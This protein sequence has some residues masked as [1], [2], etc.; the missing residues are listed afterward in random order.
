MHLGIARLVGILGRGR[1]ID[2]L[3]LRDDRIE[4]LRG[5]FGSEV[6]Q[7]GSGDE[8]ALNIEIILDSGMDA[9]KALGG[10]C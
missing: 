7:R 10:L 2:D 1:C 5:G 6:S 4:P 9:E 3:R 8:M